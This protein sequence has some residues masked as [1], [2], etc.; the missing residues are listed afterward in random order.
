MGLIVGIY[1]KDQFYIL[2]IIND[3]NN[4]NFHLMENHFSKQTL[5]TT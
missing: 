3:G 2:V 1:A 5:L 4:N